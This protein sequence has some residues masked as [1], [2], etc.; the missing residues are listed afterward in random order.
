MVQYGVVWMHGLTRGICAGDWL[1]PPM[2]CAAYPP[3][4]EG[5]QEVL[6]CGEAVGA[7]IYIVLSCLAT[8]TAAWLV[9]TLEPN[10]AGAGIPEVKAI[11][12]GAEITGFASVRMLFVKWIALVLAVGGSLS[13]GKAAPIVHIAFCI[14]DTVAGQF[15]KYRTS[16]GKRREL[17]TAAVAAGICVAFG[18]PLGGVLYAFEET[19]TFFN[20]QTLYRS[21]LCSVV[22]G[23]TLS[24]WDP[25]EQGKLTLFSIDYQVK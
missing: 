20:A 16:M 24:A 14:G 12:G 1:L 7:V 23:A 21:F 25:F 2:L 22:A 8:C 9:T 13:I 11:L 5:W 10:A 19:S 3:G 4:F 18:A 17:L 15:R 6:G